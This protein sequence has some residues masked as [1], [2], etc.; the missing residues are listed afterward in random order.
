MRRPVSP[1]QSENPLQG[2]RGLEAQKGNRT[3]HFCVLDEGG[4]VVERGKIPTTREGFR[5]RFEGVTPMQIALE[6]GTHSPWVSR[7]LKELGHEVLVANPRKTRLIY[8]NRRKQ[9]SV[10]AEALARIARLDPKLLYPVEHRPESA[11][12]DLAVLRARDALVRTRTL[13]VNHVRGAVKAT[14]Y[15]VKK[16]S[17]RTFSD[18]AVDQPF[19]EEPGSRALS[20]ART[21]AKPERRLRPATAHHERGGQ[22]AA[23]PSGPVGAVTS[24]GRSERTAT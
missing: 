13:L 7:L 21:G 3:S 6:V 4:T 15:R 17:A 8:E 22:L 19:P 9:D 16:C 18:Q 2:H 10:D 23:P 11:A 5:K 1:A 14:G 20:R 12:Q 24:W